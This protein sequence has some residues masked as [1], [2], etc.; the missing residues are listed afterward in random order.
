MMR[1]LPFLF[2]VALATS[3]CD[4]THMVTSYG[5]SVRQAFKVQVIDPC[6]GERRA[7]EQGLDPEEAAIVAASYRRS[8]SPEK[9]EP[10]RTPLVI[11]PTSP[12]PGVPAAPLPSPYASGTGTR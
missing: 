4:R 5:H 10:G 1:A 12:Q 6:A 2:I 3:A 9:Q 7:V 8:L 11:V